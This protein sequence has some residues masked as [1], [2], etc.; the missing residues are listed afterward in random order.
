MLCLVHFHYLNV[1]HQNIIEKL[2]FLLV[3][4]ILNK[5]HIKEFILQNTNSKVRLILKILY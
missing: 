4:T 5:Q 2:N 3:I 1:K